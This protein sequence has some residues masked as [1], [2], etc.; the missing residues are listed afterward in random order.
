MF[1]T[2]LIME[3]QYTAE[4]KYVTKFFFLLRFPIKESIEYE[5]NT[6]EHCALCVIASK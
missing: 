4:K 5:Y 2:T 6:L 3:R 1:T